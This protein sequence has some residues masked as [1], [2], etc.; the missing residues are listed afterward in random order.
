MITIIDAV[1]RSNSNGEKFVSLILTGGLEM[2]KSASGKFYATARK[3]SVPCTLE[4]KV[5][6]TMIGTKMPGNIVKR[7]CEPYIYT[8]PKGEEIELSFTYEY[9]ETNSELEE[10]LFS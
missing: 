9:T 5:A 3:A 6:K 7:P 10:A 8:T 1:E 2:V 4:L